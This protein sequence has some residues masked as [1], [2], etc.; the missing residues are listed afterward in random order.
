MTSVIV[1]SSANVYAGG[2]TRISGVTHGACLLISVLSLSPILNR[3]PLAS[4]AAVLII[5]GYK[6][7]NPKLVKQVR[8]AGYDQLLPFAVTALGVVI[9][10]LLTGVMI[11][12]IFGLTVVLIMNHHAAFTIISDDSSFYIRFAKDVTFLQKIALKKT[13]AQLPNNSSIVIDGNGAMFIDHDILE[14]IEDFKASARNR[15]IRV[16]IRNFSS[17]KFD[18]LSAFKN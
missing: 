5:V 1:R 14:L 3:I 2:R 17:V 13:L 4:L 9:F 12:T 11:G 18:F 16:E 7:A 8:A 6:L 10:D 15:D